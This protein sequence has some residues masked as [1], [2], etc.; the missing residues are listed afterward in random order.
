MRRVKCVD[1]QGK[2][3]IIDGKAKAAKHL[4]AATGYPW[5]EY[6]VQ[7]AADTA[8]DIVGFQLSWATPEEI[9][10]HARS[11]VA[12]AGEESSREDDM[13]QDGAMS[14]SNAQARREQSI[15]LVHSLCKH[16]HLTYRTSVCVLQGQ[17]G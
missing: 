2:I 1:P 11:A 8:K 9:Q 6:Y 13:Q 3:T 4:T 15:G 14:V 12:E 7:Q 17:I 5:S 16:S 10:Q